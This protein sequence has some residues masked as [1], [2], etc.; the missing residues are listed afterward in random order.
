M[1]GDITMSQK[2]IQR[3][4]VLEQVTSG[5]LKLIE[6][7]EFLGISYRQA[8]RLKLK[9]REAGPVGIIHGNRERIPSNVLDKNTKK[10]I[11]E[12][13]ER[14]YAD[15]NDTHFAEM[16][17]EQEG[18]LISRE[19]VRKI[20]R[21]NGQGPKRKRRAVK[22]R[23]RRP[24]KP[25]TGM[26]VQWDGSPHHWFGQH[27]PPCCLL[28]AID[29]ADTKLLAALF[30]PEEASEG[31][32]RLLTMLLSCHGVPLAIYHDRHSIFV[33]TD[34]S[35]SIEEQLQGYQYPT[36]VGR[37]LQDLNI[38]S[39]QAFSPQA[40]GRVERGFGT[41]QDRLTAE[42]AREGITDMEKANTWLQ[43]VFINRYNRRFAKKPQSA[44]S[45][46]RKISKSEIYLKVS[47][48]YEAVVGNDNCVRL[49]GLIIDIPKPKT[50]KSYARK[51]VLVRHHVDGKWSVWDN[52]IKI[53]THERTPF[54]EP[55]RSWKRRTPGDIRKG[56]HA[57]QVYISSKPASSSRGHN[58]FAVRG[59][60]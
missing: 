2:E 44:I 41:L 24:R 42:L 5:A 59:T 36:H 19:S 22:H 17:Q 37:V 12:L 1:K 52:D 53:A 15:F 29:D 60:Y 39:V 18:I 51:R 58:R 35:W 21:A 7:K 55:V 48:G 38:C 31:Y 56:K 33:R 45:S 14:E 46:F 26:L 11:I 40:K 34:E 23:S 25:S 20:R 13:S 28:S 4:R 6:A 32:L 9:Y 10:L 47:Y 57:L 3:V 30:V 49:G 43:K 8:K 27:N 16:L 50:R 54:K